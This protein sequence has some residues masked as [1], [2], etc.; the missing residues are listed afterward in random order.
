M[1]IPYQLQKIP[2]IREYPGWGYIYFIIKNNE[3][4]YIGKTIAGIVSRLSDFKKV[5]QK[6][7]DKI[8][9]ITVPIEKLDYTEKKYIFK[10]KPKHNS[11][12][13]NPKKQYIQKNLSFKTKIL[14]NTEKLIFIIKQKNLSI[15]KLAEKANILRGSLYYLLKHKSTSSIT[16]F[17]LNKVLN[18]KSNELLLIL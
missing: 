10:F 5:K 8:Y 17:K 1:N 15:P 11:H 9:H 18:L 3:I 2:N 14:I 7:Y 4:I 6:L 13:S 12:I 16:L